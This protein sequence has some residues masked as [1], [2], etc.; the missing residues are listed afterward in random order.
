LAPVLSCLRENKLP[1][2]IVRADGVFVSV[3]SNCWLCFSIPRT[4]GNARER[5]RHH[6]R[7]ASNTASTALHFPDGGRES[8]RGRNRSRPGRCSCFNFA[9]AAGGRG[10]GPCHVSCRQGF[11]KCN[12]SFGQRSLG[13]EVRTHCA[14]RQCVLCCAHKT[15]L[16][17]S[18]NP[19]ILV[20]LDDLRSRPASNDMSRAKVRHRESARP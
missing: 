9:D 2:Y 5:H 1:P 18:M 4:S 13:R 15:G 16:T 10:S 3:A 17:A 19:D 6:Q 11:S 8:S 12:G 20:L 14:T 7:C